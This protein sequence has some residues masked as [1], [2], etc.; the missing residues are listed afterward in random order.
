MHLDFCFLCYVHIYK[1]P[2]IRATQNTNI[3]GIKFDW[4][5][6]ITQDILRL[7]PLDRM[8]VIFCMDL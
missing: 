6:V 5:L 7:V 3:I 4:R 8:Y 1:G 2:R